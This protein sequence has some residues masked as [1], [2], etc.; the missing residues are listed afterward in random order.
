[1]VKNI[2]A[3]VHCVLSGGLSRTLLTF[4][5]FR[6][7][8]GRKSTLH[9]IQDF[10]VTTASPLIIKLLYSI[11]FLSKFAVTKIAVK[12]FRTFILFHYS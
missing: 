3:Q 10:K 8:A 11:H 1:M 4:L 9:P 6:E 12:E 7:M 2:A 5:S